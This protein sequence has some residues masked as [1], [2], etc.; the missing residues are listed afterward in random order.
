MTGSLGRVGKGGARPFVTRPFAKKLQEHSR[1][2]TLDREEDKS[3]FPKNVPDR[4]EYKSDFR[5]NVLKTFPLKSLQ[6]EW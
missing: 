5:K 4:E 1:N 2:R 3:D 6:E